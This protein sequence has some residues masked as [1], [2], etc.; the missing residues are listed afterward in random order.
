MLDFEQVQDRK[1]LDRMWRMVDK[2][3]TAKG[4]RGDG[5]PVLVVFEGEFYGPP[6]PDQRLPEPIKRIYHPGW[7]S[8]ATTKLVVRAVR[9]FKV[10]PAGDPCKPP[11]SNP[12]DWPCFQ[13]D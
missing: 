1:M 9:S 8:N 2:P 7:D 6:I 11:K 5:A 10:L 4:V 12:T 3:N 13:K